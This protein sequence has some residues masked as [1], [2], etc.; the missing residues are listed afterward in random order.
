MKKPLLV[1]INLTGCARQGVSGALVP[2]S[3]LCGAE[4]PLEGL[5]SEI[6]QVI[7]AGLRATDGHEPRQVRKEAA[8][9]DTVCVVD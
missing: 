2:K 6:W 1:A 4:F 8:I 7:P 5:F 3:A 9:S